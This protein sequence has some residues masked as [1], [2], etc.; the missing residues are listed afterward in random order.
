MRKKGCLYG[1]IGLL[2]VLSAFLIWYFVNQSTGEEKS[3]DFE[4]PEITDIVKKAVATGAV[5]PRKEVQ[6]KP[7]VS[8]VIEELYVEAGS[9]V[10]K[11]QK[12]AKI[13]LV[14][15]E[16]SVNNA[17]NSVE[18]ARIRLQEAQRELERQK[19]V[20]DNKLDIESARAAFENARQ[21]EKRSKQLLDEGV[22]SEQEYQRNKMMLEQQETAFENAKLISNNAIKAART[23]V[24][25]RRQELDAAINNLQLLREG[26]AQNSRQVANIVSSTV[27][28]MVLDIP[29]EEGTSVIERNNFNEGTT[30]ASVADM[31]S[32]VFEGMVDESDVGKIK[33]GM[34]LELTVG[35]IQNKKFDATL[36]Y[37]SPKGVEEE[38][39][40]KFEIRAAIQPDEEYFLRAGYSASGDIILEKKQNV[41]SIKERDVLFEGDTTYVEIKTGEESVDKKQIEI[42][43]SDGI[44]VEIVS[45]LDTTQSV[46]IQQ[47]L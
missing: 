14:P 27:D 31:N 16:T 22:I 4:K 9:I 11:G 17:Q 18:L 42:G 36:E 33:E 40:V 37:I 47:K 46:K 44:Q 7:Q 35:A 25:I 2:V 3:L 43:I 12:I 28:G 15:S 5:R 29:V 1:A 38:G 26:A 24:D 21:E 10:S 41:V 19:S 34:P 8:G 6:I 20:F 39:S 45:G 13:K 23:E 32:L 30:I